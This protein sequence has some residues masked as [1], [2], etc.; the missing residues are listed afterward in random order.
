MEI[1]K[2]GMWEELKAD[3]LEKMMADLMAC[4]KVVK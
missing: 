2:V 1:V 4:L 3:E